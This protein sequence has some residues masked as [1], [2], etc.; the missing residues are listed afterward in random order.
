MTQW[1]PVSS[2]VKWGYHCLS[3]GELQRVNGGQYRKL[4][5][6]GHTSVPFLCPTYNTLI[7]P[8]FSIYRQKI[9]PLEISQS[10]KITALDALLVVQ[11]YVSL[12]AQTIKNP[13]AVQETWVRSLGQE[14]PL[15]KGM[16]THS[17]IIT[18]RIP[19]TEKPGRLLSMESQES[20]I[21][22]PPPPPSTSIRSKSWPAVAPAL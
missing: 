1:D 13:P 6:D 5:S 20:D 8:L 21:T 7:L 9:P 4:I 3:H 11:T 16:A 22:K 2:S 12:V 15:E 18:W 10:M 14:D 17:S 19:W